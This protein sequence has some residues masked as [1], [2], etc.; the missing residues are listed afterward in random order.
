MISSG[1]LQL[2]TDRC[3][4]SRKSRGWARGDCADGLCSSVRRFLVTM[5]LM[6]NEKYDE[7]SHLKG[8]AEWRVVA[9]LPFVVPI[10]STVHGYRGR[11]CPAFFN[12]DCCLCEMSIFEK[13][14]GFKFMRTCGPAGVFV[15][16]CVQVGT[17]GSQSAL[18]SPT[19]AI[20]GGCEPYDV[21]AGNTI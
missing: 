2:G 1:H 5:G 7:L 18:G 15:Y 13:T 4:A 11:R 20:T 10:S 3:W 19:T 12:V 6:A 14:R 21:G 17:H 8:S 16:Y 9:V